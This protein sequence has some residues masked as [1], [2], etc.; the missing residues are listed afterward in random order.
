MLAHGGRFD[1]IA[2][3]IW[4]DSP[5]GISFF[6]HGGEVGRQRKSVKDAPLITTMKHAELTKGA[7]E[8]S[9]WRE[10]IC[11]VLRPEKMKGVASEANFMND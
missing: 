10:H 6:H 8:D 4:L 1:I 3:E 11:Q 2:Q 5:E 9:S 7:E